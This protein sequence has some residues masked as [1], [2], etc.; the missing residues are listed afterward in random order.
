MTANSL[1]AMTS[2][3]LL[4]STGALLLLHAL[5]LVVKAKK[6]VSLVEL[7]LVANAVALI[8]WR[9]YSFLIGQRA[10]LEPPSAIAAGVLA[11]VYVAA[12]RLLGQRKVGLLV[13]ASMALI[14]LFSF[15]FFVT[16]E[17]GST[18]LPGFA[19]GS[20]SITTLKLEDQK[21]QNR[22]YLSFINLSGVRGEYYEDKLCGRSIFLEC[23]I[24]NS[25]PEDVGTLTLSGTLLS[26]D[27]CVILQDEF[28]PVSKS[29]PLRTGKKLHVMTRFSGTPEGWNPKNIDV[30]IIELRIAGNRMISAATFPTKESKK[31]K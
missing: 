23:E 14:A 25:G 9:I 12:V 18:L 30:R 22:E 29:A 11:L 27:G 20:R 3:I 17:E 10:G 6:L 24:R 8:A 4:F 13:W 1:N 16:Q 28:Y 26:E 31:D 15:T 19:G 7:A 5:C 21:R 2:T